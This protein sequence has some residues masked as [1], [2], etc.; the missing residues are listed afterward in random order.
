MSNI[1]FK[2]YMLSLHCYN[3]PGLRIDIVLTLLNIK[4]C[5]N[6]SYLLKN[7]IGF[8]HRCV[9]LG[10]FSMKKK[11][12]ENTNVC[13]LVTN[14]W[15]FKLFL[16]GFIRNGCF[17]LAILPIIVEKKPQTNNKKARKIRKEMTSNCQNLQS[18]FYT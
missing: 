13:C 10:T 6:F 8:I 17:L 9:H 2:V 7:T 16:N 18:I 1:Y 11:L 5:G 15:Q 14:A 12:S 4:L 3:N